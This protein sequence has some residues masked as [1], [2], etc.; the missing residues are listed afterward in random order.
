MEVNDGGEGPAEDPEA[1]ARSPTVHPLAQGQVRQP[2]H[3][4][5]HQGQEQQLGE[6]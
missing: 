1:G 6:V 4:E 5:G 2:A 3:T